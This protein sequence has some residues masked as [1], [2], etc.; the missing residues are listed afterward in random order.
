VLLVH[1]A[2][3]RPPPRDIAASVL[4]TLGGCVLAGA[5]DLSFDG[6][7]YSYA[8][9]SCALQ[10]AYMI[11]IE[12]V[13]QGLS[14]WE[15]LLYNSLLSAP[16]LLL[17]CIANGELQSATETLPALLSGP[18]GGSFAAT[19]SAVL[20]MGVLLNFAQFW[21]VRVNNALTTTIVGVLKSVAVVLLGFVL[22]GGVRDAPPAHV[23]GMLIS[24]AGGAWYAMLEYKA[25]ESRK[26]AS[27][28]AAEALLS[29]GDAELGTLAPAEAARLEAAQAGH[30]LLAAGHA[31]ESPR[32]SS[33][34]SLSAPRHR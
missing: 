11:T 31:G 5:S 27:A 7:A 13:R 6:L 24:A 25:K 10:T 1:A 2:S 4:V 29:E 23:G 26:A 17:M 8:V 3:G 28:A 22:L 9:A 21:C 30:D 14:S 16:M 20:F 34:M 19:F 15:L 33:T 18:D 12:R 32:A